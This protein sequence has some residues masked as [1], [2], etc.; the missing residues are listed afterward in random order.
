M[1][2]FLTHI[3]RFGHYKS[4]SPDRFR[5]KVTSLAKKY[6]RPLP[7]GLFN[8]DDHGKS[9]NQL[10]AIR[11]GAGRGHGRIDAIGAEATALLDTVAPQITAM[12]KEDQEGPIT[13]RQYRGEVTAEQV[14]S[15]RRYQVRRIVLAKPPGGSRSKKAEQQRQW[16]ERN[17]ND[18]SGLA[19]IIKAKIQDGLVAQATAFGIALPDDFLL[20]TIGVDSIGTIPFMGRERRGIVAKKT[21]FQSNLK[22]VGPWH[23]GYL[24][25][26][27]YGLIHDTQQH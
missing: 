26:R 19:A 14:D 12:F 7:P 13:E 16:L 25:T 15:L 4:V 21:T 22:L 27:G 18:K 8:F 23:V 2:E 9:L 11:F 1:C 20:G 24:Q 3:I 5:K 6:N 10:A 17:P